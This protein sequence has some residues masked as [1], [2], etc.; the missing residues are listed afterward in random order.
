MSPACLPACL[1]ACMHACMPACL[2]NPL[3]CLPSSTPQRHVNPSRASFPE[4]LAVGVG[5]GAID[6]S[7]RM[8]KAAVAKF[9][10]ARNLAI[11]IGLQNFPEGLAVS[12]PLRRQGMSLWK[13]LWYGQL[14][15]LVEPVGGI[16]GAYLV[17][18]CNPVLPYA[19][20]FAAGAMVYVVVDDLVPE[21]HEGG[22]SRLSTCGCM[23][24]F[25]TMM[26]LDVGLG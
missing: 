20:A 23:V 25:L 24:G 8:S 16:L 10:N 21:A 26:S 7:D 15:G 1:P 11:G 17:Q 4:G 2:P 22:N 12:M 19:L 3:V 6:P 9:A 13:S 14:S 18:L 5:F